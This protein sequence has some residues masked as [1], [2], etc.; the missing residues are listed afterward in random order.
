MPGA[1]ESRTCFVTPRLFIGSKGVWVM[2]DQ[3]AGDVSDLLKIAFLRT[4]AADDRTIGVGWYY[5]PEHDGRYQDGRHRDYCDEP[6]WE[7]FD[8]PLY[9]ALREMRKSAERSVKVL[10]ELP[11]WPH[12]TLFHRV[13]VPFAEKRGVWAA[14]MKSMLREASIIFLDPDN[15]LGTLSKRHTIVGEVKA[16]RQPGRA[17]VLIKFPGHGEKHARQIETYHNLLRD[18]AGA[19]SIATVCTCVSVSVVNKNGLRQRVPRVRWFTIIDAGEVL[20][21]R[22]K[23]F[24][25]RLNGIEK[26]GAGV[27]CASRFTERPACYIGRINSPIA[28]AMPPQSSAT[29]RTL[30][31][32]YVSPECDYNFKGNGFDG[33]DA[34]WKARHEQLIPYK[35]AWPVIK[36]GNYHRK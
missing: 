32:E 34:H 8:V 14:D 2:R 6:K 28:V 23:Q 36:S 7:V 4:L 24:V 27:V 10:E 18:Q 15:G 29:D 26:C 17:V 33:I 3:Y 11:I 31:V 21:E 30:R 12:N 19:E 20:I 5:N 35:N 1:T 9:T 25:H 22:A 16:M 13:S